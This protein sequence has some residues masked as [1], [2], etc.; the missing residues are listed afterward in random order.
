MT[1]HAMG[2]VLCFVAGWIGGSQGWLSFAAVM[3]GM[4]GMAIVGLP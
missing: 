4:A 3:I 2:L 1:F